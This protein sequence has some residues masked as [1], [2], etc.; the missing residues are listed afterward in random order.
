MF[1]IPQNFH[2]SEASPDGDFL[3]GFDADGLPVRLPGHAMLGGVFVKGENDHVRKSVVRSLLESSIASGRGLVYFC[4]GDPE[5][6]A[7][8]FAIASSYGR[9]D[10]V[11]VLNFMTGNRGADHHS[12]TC[13][14]FQKGTP[15]SHAN[16]IVSLLDD[17][18]G[19]SAMWKG[20]GT[21]LMLGILR[22]LWWLRDEARADLD[23]STVRNMLSISR[24]VDLAYSAEFAELP[25]SIRK[26]VRSYLQS[27]PGFDPAKGYKQSQTTLDQHGYLDMQFT[28][29]IGSLADIYGH[30]FGS[31]HGDVDMNSV[32]GGDRI[33]VV[34][35]PVLEKSPD[36]VAQIATIVVGNLSEM[37]REA[38][39]S[40]LGGT[41]NDIVRKKRS[42]DGAIPFLCLTQDIGYYTV[43][44]MSMLTA[45]AR[46][47]GFSLVVV[48]GK[49]PVSRRLDEKEAPAVVAGLATTISV[50][51]PDPWEGMPI[52]VVSGGQTVLCE[53]GKTSPIDDGFTVRMVHPNLL[54]YD[55]EASRL[56]HTRHE[57]YM[58]FTASVAASG[59][60]ATI[61]ARTLTF[62]HAL[63]RSET[64]PSSRMAIQRSFALIAGYPKLRTIRTTDG[65]G[66][67]LVRLGD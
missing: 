23:V 66:E 47:L 7:R 14:P 6:Y 67:R 30:I 17:V 31:R 35:L 21:A 4:A 62:A 27:L 33:L 37:W 11:Q 39:G 51:R 3:V 59:M 34:M 61:G 26:S 52:R 46:S 40:T 64:E 19:D 16:T 57:R 22:A 63:D 13:N 29:I 48:E 2:P 38:M 42:T 65:A 15:E 49:P 45:Q 9:Q 1:T 10:D 12:N 32:L 18:G 28:K 5:D 58:K 20:R 54:R 41:W 55:A 43:G 44:S 60:A 36:E 56:F 25:E 8:I 24:V 50:S 53:P